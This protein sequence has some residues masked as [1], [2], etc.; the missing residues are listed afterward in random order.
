MMKLHP[1][2]IAAG[3]VCAAALWP[4][5]AAPE[6]ANKEPIPN[7]TPEGTT[8]WI[9]DRALSHD[10]FLPPPSGPGPVTFDK[11]HPYVPN[12][13]G[14]RPS[15]RVAD[16]TNPILKPWAVEQMRKANQDVLAGKFAFTAKSGCWPG[17]VPGIL[18]FQFEPLYIVQTPKIVWMIW[19]FDS[20]VR[21]IYLNQPH[22]KNPK[23]GWFGESVGHYEGDTLVVDTIGLSDKAFIDF[24]RT[25]HTGKLHVIERYRMIDGGKSLEVNFTV[26]DPG[27]FNMVWS[28]SQ[29]YGRVQQRPLIETICAE[30]IPR[31]FSYDIPPI[32]EANKPD[33]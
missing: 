14:E 3:L 29:R 27:A 31:Y 10:D 7:F 2:A 18:L 25:P 12:G 9:M 13:Q 15:F 8:G 28:A 6:S 24:Y 4:S 1:L 21:R 19:E 32:P 33:F 16:V 22:S 5:I 23:P 26:D 17:S 11:A 20:Q 30:N